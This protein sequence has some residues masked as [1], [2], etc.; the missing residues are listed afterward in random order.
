MR[1]E[2]EHPRPQLPA[3]LDAFGKSSIA[4]LRIPSRSGAWACRG[5]Y[6]ASGLRLSGVPVTIAAIA[7][8]PIDSCAPIDG[9]AARAARKVRHTE[10]FAR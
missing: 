4:D 1:H 5:D 9:K 10:R 3:T 6:Q 2:N 7:R 8:S